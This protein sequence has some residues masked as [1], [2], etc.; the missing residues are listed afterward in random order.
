MNYLSNLQTFLQDIDSHLL[1]LR[2]QRQRTPMKL[3]Q[4]CDHIIS[5]IQTKHG[6]KEVIGLTVYSRPLD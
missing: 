1:V 3:N 4:V 2:F 6:F 5:H